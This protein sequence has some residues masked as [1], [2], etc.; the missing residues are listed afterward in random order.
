M[1]VDFGPHL[2]RDTLLQ[3]VVVAG[4]GRAVKA[5]V[6]VCESSEYK[7]GQRLDITLTVNG[8]ELPI[9]EFCEHWQAQVDEMITARAKELVE[10]RMGA[11][12]DTI[13]EVTQALRERLDTPDPGDPPCSQ[14]GSSNVLF[15]DQHVVGTEGRS[16]TLA[17][18][19]AACGHKTSDVP[20]KDGF[21]RNAVAKV[22]AAWRAETR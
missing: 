16:S 8:H 9:E 6:E 20:Y 7:E 17:F 18:V 4:L 22:R 1:I 3:H 13:F 15:R 12:S 14:C 10:E 5:C 11:I 21:L 2:E 19:C